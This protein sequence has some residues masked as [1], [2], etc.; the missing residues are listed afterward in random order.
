MSSECVVY[1]VLGDF[2]H[3]RKPHTTSPAQSFGIPP[4]TTVAGMTAAILGLDRDSYYETFGRE[5]S[6]IAI[7]L[8][9]PI[10][11]LSLAINLVNTEGSDAKTKGAT[12]GK[13]FRDNRQQNVFEYLCDPQYRLYV[14]L[15]DG[16]LLDDLMDLLR[17]GKSVYA[18]SLGLSEHIA[19]TEFVGRFE[20]VEKTGEARVRSA[21]PGENIPLIPEPDANYVSE[22]VPGYM[23]A[24]NPGGRVS[25]GHV[26]FTYDR[27]GSDLHLRETDYAE[28]GD[29][30]VIFS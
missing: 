21:V 8:E 7:S 9:A 5:S 17:E 12:P 14:S 18:P 22:R 26:Q 6:R 25:D 2:A 1:D 4:R 13:F 23:K 27:G 24:H 30:A 29:D 11:R 19:K 16:S 20:I 3:F 10:R 28:V 15:D